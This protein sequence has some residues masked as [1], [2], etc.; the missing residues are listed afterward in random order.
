MVTMNTTQTELVEHQSELKAEVSAVVAVEIAVTNQ[1][2][3]A[4]ANDQIGKLQTVRKAI[5]ER[6]SDPKK[7]A[8]EAHKAICAL[9]KT[10]LNPVDERIDALKAST[11]RWYAAEQARIEAEAER[12]RKEAEEMARLAQEAEAQGDIATAEEAV[13]EAAMA[14][15]NVTYMPKVKGTSMREVWHAV[16][17]D[18]AQVPRE[19]LMVN[20]SA[21]DA[22]AKATKGAIKIPGVRFEKSYINS[23]RAK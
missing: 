15:A 21:L 19:Y 23:T 12:K 4:A 1:E 8:A 14:E 18:E 6:F 22:V 3:Y 5:V 10:F 20:Q 13:V 11:T 9:E 7:K 17:E 16:V 2:T